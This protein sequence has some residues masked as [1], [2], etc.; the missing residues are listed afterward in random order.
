MIEG[1]V[2]KAKVEEYN[3]RRPQTTYAVLPMLPPL[4]RLT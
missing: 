3:A 1:E 2:N 4:S